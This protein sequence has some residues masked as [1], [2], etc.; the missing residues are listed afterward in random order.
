MNCVERAFSHR[1]ASPDK[2]ALWTVDG[3]A[4]S[5]VQLFE[6]AA[7]AQKLFQR[8]GLRA[9]DH[10]LVML[11][12]GPALFAA[13]LALA[14]LGACAVL[15][16]PWMPVARIDHVLGS[17]RPRLFLAGLPGRLWGLRI[18][19]VRRIPHWIGRRALAGETSPGPFRVEETPAHHPASIAFS[20][21]T[22]GAPKGVVRTHGY[23]WDLHALLA[24]DE[25]PRRAAGPDLS[26]FANVA[27]FHLGTGRG[28][29]CVPPRWSPGNLRRAAAA[30]ATLGAE[31]VSAGPAFLLQLLRTQGF[32]TLRSFYV[33]G[34]LTDC[35]ILEDG[36][37]RWPAAKWTHIYGGTEAE[38]VALSDAREAVA[39][40]RARG[41]F[42]TLFLGTPIPEVRADLTP[43]AAW[44]AGPNV[45]GE[46]L[47]A[48]D[49]TRLHKRRDAAG[50]LWHDMGDRVVADADGWWFAGRSAQPHEDFAREQAIY[51]HLESSASFIQRDPTGRPWLAGEGVAART[52]EIRTRHPGLDLAG[53]V[54]LRIRRDRRHRARIDRVASLKK[55]APWLAG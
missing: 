42:Q 40:S 14:A 44:V 8:R 48:P 3:G 4:L 33:G 2:M 16:E 19:A 53:T 36:F 49:E 20:S 28:A 6:L 27:L 17:V 29:I 15:V 35:W 30:A 5:F 52:A 11:P 21:G 22:T 26:V 13:T 47:G 39:K 38:P 31:S 45:C 34:A 23:L 51:A 9:G 7:R 1:Q 32:D 37:R 18:P 25:D 46:Y 55:G 10:A 24:R 54:E 50:V 12:P 43:D 41:H